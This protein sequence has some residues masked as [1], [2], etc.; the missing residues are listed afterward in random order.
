[1]IESRLVLKI[2]RVAIPMLVALFGLGSLV[3]MIVRPGAYG[4]KNRKAVILTILFWLAVIAVSAI[5][6]TLV[7]RLTKP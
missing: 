4:I 1:M 6:W 7:G 3:T 5:V 2:L